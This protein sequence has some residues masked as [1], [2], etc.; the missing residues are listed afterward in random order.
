MFYVHGAQLR[1]CVII[2]K[3]T[4]DNLVAHN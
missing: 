1:R 4:V 2:I 3:L